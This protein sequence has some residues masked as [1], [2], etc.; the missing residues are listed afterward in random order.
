MKP[1]VIYIGHVDM[2]LPTFDTYC[3]DI[4]DETKDAYIIPALTFYVSL[5]PYSNNNM[6]PKRYMDNLICVDEKNQYYIIYSLDEHVV[7][8]FVKG[9]YNK[10][11]DEARAIVEEIERTSIGYKHIKK[12]D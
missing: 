7:F 4:L 6:I 8:E 1:E 9:F 3:I 2:R 10:K 5:A 11:L 12:D